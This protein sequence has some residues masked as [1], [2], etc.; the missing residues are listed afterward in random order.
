MV[1]DD[2]VPNPPSNL[3]TGTRLFGELWTAPTKGSDLA[4]LR[5]DR[6]R[7]PG[8]TEFPVCTVATDNGYLA[9]FE[10]PESGV[11]V[12]GS[13]LPGRVVYEWPRNR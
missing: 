3:P 7:L 10:R 6:A 2:D 12:A 9:V 4:Y 8:G 11:I 13:G 5:F 1:I